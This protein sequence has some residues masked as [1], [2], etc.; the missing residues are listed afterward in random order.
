MLS[1]RIEWIADDSFLGECDTFRYEFIVD[2][3]MHKCTRC[4]NTILCCVMKDSF[5]S[6]IDGKINCKFRF[7]FKLIQRNHVLTICIFTDDQRRFTTCVQKR[8]RTFQMTI[9]LLGLPSSSVT[10]FRFDLAAPS[11]IFLPTY[12]VNVI[13]LYFVFSSRLTSTEPVNDTLSMC[14][15]T[16]IALPHLGPSPKRKQ[17]S[18]YHEQESLIDDLAQYWQRLVENQP[19]II[20][21]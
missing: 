7:K 19:I 8:D 6:D 12:K 10:R 20:I 15:W 11:W 1:I 2:F 18:D 5:V 3:R 14:S 17:R 9:H 16:T 4:S 13:I 21:R